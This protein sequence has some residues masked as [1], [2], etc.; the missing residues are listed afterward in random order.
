MQQRGR[1]CVD[2]ASPSRPLV[3][4]TAFA[5]IVLVSLYAPGAARLWAPLFGIVAGTLVARPELSGVTRLVP[6]AVARFQGRGES[7]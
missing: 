5:T 2:P 3:A 7:G 6:R 4:L 1:G